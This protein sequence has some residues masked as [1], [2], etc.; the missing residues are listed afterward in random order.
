MGWVIFAV[1]VIAIIGYSIY[2]DKS[3]SPKQIERRRI[4]KEVE[5][6]K[7]QC[8]FYKYLIHVGGHPSFELNEP[9]RFKIRNNQIFISTRGLKETIKLNVKDI[10]NYEVQTESEIKNN[11]T[12]PRVLIL[13]ILSLVAK[14]QSTDTKYFLILTLKQNNVKFQSIFKG[15]YSDDNLYD[16]ITEINRLKIKSVNN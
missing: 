2:E 12:I 14:K 5:E 15:A 7:S 3:M 1:V 9:V 16:I 8:S 11:V 10:I 4:R 13:G 6:D